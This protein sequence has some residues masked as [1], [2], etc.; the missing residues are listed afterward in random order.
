MNTA[1]LVL[2]LAQRDRDWVDITAPDLQQIL[3]CCYFNALK[4]VFS[5]CA[6]VLHPVYWIRKYCY[7][8]RKGFNI[9]MFVQQTKYDTGV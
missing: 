9:F 1:Q 6:C 3:V 8:L 4:S 5:A 7:N 2:R